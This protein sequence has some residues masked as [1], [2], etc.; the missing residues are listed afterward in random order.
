[1][2]SVLL[3]SI[4]QVTTMTWQMYHASPGVTA[5]RPAHQSQCILYTAADDGLCNCRYLSRSR[6]VCLT[7]V[8]RVQQGRLLGRVPGTDARGALE[9]HV[10]QQMRQAWRGEWDQSVFIMYPLAA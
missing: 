9:G 7:F 10:L 8:E 6:R 5:Q 4:M 1:M 3:Q 2:H